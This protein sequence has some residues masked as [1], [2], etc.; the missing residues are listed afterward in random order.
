MFFLVF[1][2]A[3]PSNNYSNLHSSKIGPEEKCSRKWLA[4]PILRNHHVHV[5]PSAA[6]ECF[7]SCLK[8]LCSEARDGSDLR[9]LKKQTSFK[10]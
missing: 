7:S 5:P 6:V 10:A 8:G 1:L 4:A 3:A 9:S 2:L